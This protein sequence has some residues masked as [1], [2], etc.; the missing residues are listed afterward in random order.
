[1]RCPAP[2][3]RAA[4][5]LAFAA[6]LAAACAASPAGVIP[7]PD[8][9]YDAFTFRAGP[10]DPGDPLLGT[11]TEVGDRLWSGSSYGTGL[12]FGSDAANATGYVAFP[13]ETLTSEASVPYEVV[14]GQH[15]V[16]AADVRPRSTD[17]EDWV[18]IGFGVPGNDPFAEATFPEP[19]VNLTFNGNP[20][21][22]LRT[23]GEYYVF[24]GPG[25]TSEMGRGTASTYVRGAFNRME[26]EYDTAT[27]SVVFRLNGVPQPLA[28]ATVDR[29]VPITGAGFRLH[30]TQHG[31][32]DNF[33][34][35]GVVPEPS[36]LPL[37]AAAAAALLVLQRPRRTTR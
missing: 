22:L 28:D 9:V 30:R 34:V 23:N 7:A 6:A 15:V 2:I 29:P 33:L 14:E 27:D 13:G 5:T 12:R 26:L 31:D 3:A 24:G 25:T 11:R 35:A 19:H 4:R 16:V 20:W 18:A 32:V 37:A 21:A 10:R 36:P 1:M 8:V 17:P